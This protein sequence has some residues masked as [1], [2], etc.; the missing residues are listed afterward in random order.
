MPINE[1]ERERERERG[2]EY[3]KTYFQYLDN[4][5]KNYLTL[6]L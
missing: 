6:Y 4:L 3:Y 2:D 5:T 1:K